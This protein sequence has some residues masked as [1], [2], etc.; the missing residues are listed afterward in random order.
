MI[1][2]LLDK[3]KGGSLTVNDF[4]VAAKYGKWKTQTGLVIVCK[5][6]PTW[7]MCEMLRSLFFLK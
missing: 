3:E 6:L 7:Q 5:F 1:F 4:E 2:F